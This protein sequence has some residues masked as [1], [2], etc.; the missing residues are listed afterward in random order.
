M[1]MWWIDQKP[2]KFIFSMTVL[3]LIA[4]YFLNGV[5]SM[6]IMTLY[7][8][9]GFFMAMLFTIV[10]KLYMGISR[11]EVRS[12]FDYRFP[13]LHTAIG[14]TMSIIPSMFDLRFSVLV[15]LI[16]L[17]MYNRWKFKRHTWIE[18]AVG[19]LI[20]LEVVILLSFL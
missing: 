20:G 12:V 17:A 4:D 10:I 9:F 8:L 5:W 11:G 6:F 2:F 1:L 3:V 15:L 13:S 7:G 14:T 16:P 19:F 18:I